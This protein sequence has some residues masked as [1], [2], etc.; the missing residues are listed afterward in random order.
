[1]SIHHLETEI[2]E[3][4]WRAECECGWVSNS[5]DSLGLKG[6]RLAR[7]EYREHVEAALGA[8]AYYNAPVACI[9]C[10]SQH[11]QGLLI[12][13]DVWSGTCARCGASGRLRPDGLVESAKYFGGLR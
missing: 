12:G 3:R 6:N 10:G 7:Q 13:T 2:D 11:E 4:G 9:N 5:H 8:D 1:M